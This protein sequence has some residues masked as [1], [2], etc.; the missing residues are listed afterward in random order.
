MERDM[1]TTLAVT[2]LLVGAAAHA[3]ESGGTESPGSLRLEAST[4]FPL[5]LALRGTMEGPG[6]VQFA[7][8]VGFAPRAYT[9]LIH[10]TAQALGAYGPRAAQLLSS[11]YGNLLDGRALVGWRPFAE[12]G[13]YVLGGYGVVTLGGGLSIVEVLAAALGRPLPEGAQGTERLQLR[14]TA[15]QAYV[16]LGWKWTVAGWLSLG[17]GLGGFYTFAAAVDITPLVEAPALRTALEGLAGPGEAFLATQTRRYFHAPLATLT[18]G[19]VFD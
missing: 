18:A 13:F 14:A 2:L 12:S 8:S 3:Q 17:A 9:R 7:L 1:R 4:S 11:A 6:R 19:V 16:E 15:H 5:D 10:N